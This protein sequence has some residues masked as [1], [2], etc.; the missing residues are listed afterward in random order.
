[1]VTTVQ[2]P[3]NNI[4]RDQRSI[5]NAYSNTNGR[6][7]YTSPR[8]NVVH[9]NHVQTVQSPLSD[10]GTT[11]LIDFFSAPPPQQT[12]QRQQTQGMDTMTGMSRNN[13]NNPMGNS[14]GFIRN[15]NYQ[16]VPNGNPMMNR[17]FSA[18][19]VN[20][21]RNIQAQ[22]GGNSNAK[23]FLQ[24]VNQNQNTNGD[25]FAVWGF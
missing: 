7:G 14:N 18:D 19:H 16:M 20:R 9:S 2:S 1:M 15:S 13:G 10:N 5:T 23:M 11:D 3:S 12:Q 4:M 24:N 6:N 17:S 8:S 22:N 25:P 21:N